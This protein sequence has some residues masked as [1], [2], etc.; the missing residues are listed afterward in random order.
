M[1][2][3]RTDKSTNKYEYVLKETFYQGH[4][5]RDRAPRGREAESRVR[6]TG[7]HRIQVNTGYR[8]N[9]GYR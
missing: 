8:R 4:D 7:K 5:G 9:T 2:G 1:S 3:V 6:D